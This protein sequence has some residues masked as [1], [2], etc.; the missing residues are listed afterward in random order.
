MALEELLRERGAA[1]EGQ[2]AS[3]EAEAREQDSL[4]RQAAAM[5]GMT[6]EEET[7][8][9]PDGGNAWEGEEPETCGDG[10]V[11]R[12]PVQPYLVAP[13]YHAR[14]LRKGVLIVVG[15][16]LAAL[17]ALALVRAGMLRF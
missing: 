2:G 11:R 9:P 13:D 12:S 3:A 16:C 4:I 7:A 5:I 10:Y 6:G 14:R 1:A 8:P 15:I 17:L